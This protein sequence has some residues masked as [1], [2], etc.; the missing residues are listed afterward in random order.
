MLART[1]SLPCK[2]FPGPGQ[3]KCDQTQRNSVAAGQWETIFNISD[4]PCIVTNF[5]M[6]CDFLGKLRLFRWC[7]FSAD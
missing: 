5:W 4:G 6:A 1:I 7:S 2:P 3:L